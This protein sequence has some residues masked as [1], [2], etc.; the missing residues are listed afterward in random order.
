MKNIYCSK[1]SW[2]E[3]E[4]FFKSLF[5]NIGTPAVVIEES[6]IITLANREFEKISGF[7][8]EEIEYKKSIFD[9]II[10]DD[11]FKVKKYH[12]LRR[13]GSDIVPNSYESQ[14]IDKF[15]NIKN[16]LLTVAMIPGTKK[17]VVSF[18]DITESKIAKEAILANQQKFLS[19]IEFLPDATFVIDQ[20][21]KVI[22]WN[23]AMEE[24]TGVPRGAI[25]G[26]GDYAEAIYGSE[27]SI[28]IDN[29][30]KATTNNTDIMEKEIFLP[31]AY[32]GKG[33]YF[34]IIASPLFDGNGNLI[35]AIESL[36][37]ITNMRNVENQLRQAQKMEAVG[38][39]AG[40]IAHDFNNLLTGIL[41][42]VSSILADT[43]HSEEHFDA[44]KEIEQAALMAADIIEKLLGFSRKSIMQS[45]VVNVND[46]I[47]ETCKILERTIDPRIN[48]KT[49]L[50]KD[51][52]L[53][54]A[55]KTQ[56]IQILINLC[57]NS[58]DAMTEGGVITITTKNVS[59]GKDCLNPKKSYI[60]PGNFVNIT[61]SDTGC[62][63]TPEIQERIFEP[64]F[65]TKEIG[66]G[67]G[68][69]LSMVYG[70]VKQLKGWIDCY[71]EPGAGTSFTIYLPRYT[72]EK[73]P[74]VQYN[75]SRKIA[76]ISGNE[77]ILIVD[78]EKIVRN[79]TKRVLL[80]NGYKTLTAG[81]G[82]EA[83]D[84]YLNEWEKI[85]LVVLDLTMPKLSGK[86]VLVALKEINPS[87]KVL[88][89]SG[90]LFN[91]FKEPFFPECE[92]LHKP[93]TEGELL[94]QLKSLLQKE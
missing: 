29:V 32:Q 25:I 92:F 86:D 83:I 81:D 68:L 41:G 10:G 50:A 57:L 70:I 88:L 80:K 93:F 38:L 2:N 76:K 7:S 64:F 62:G 90:Y 46:S 44:L 48:I 3:S 65:T 33:A 73:N 91:D 35:G 13:I 26:T 22:A 60:R 12:L 1:K 55:D 18:F 40:G 43:S 74:E 24:M 19:V 87:V 49:D 58:Q 51:L 34:R 42:N 28:L 66:H 31:N 59:L 6:S 39:L 77:T 53:A 71:S 67:T 30:I 75:I 23:K 11:L 82:Q 9:F 27:Q 69:G 61:V 37:D 4:N 54:E 52:W 5:Y 17:S 94:S 79:F 72:G 16:I 15:G 89:T 20:N 63:M 84:I 8:I 45:N 85:D 47:F 56:I 78:D 36:H 14:I 21:K